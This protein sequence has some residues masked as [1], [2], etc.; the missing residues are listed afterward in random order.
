MLNRLISSAI[1]ILWMGGCSTS[2]EAVPV[3]QGRDEKPAG[4]SLSAQTYLRKL[5]LHLRGQTPTR[6]EYA[7]LAS[8][9]EKH[10]ATQFI[11]G[12]IDEYL[13]SDQHIDKMSGRLE[14]CFCSNP[15]RWHSPVRSSVVLAMIFQFTIL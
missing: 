12:K 6:S 5:S 15:H 11:K 4:P 3:P 9:L 13:A 10:T 8:A 7:D 1:L 2:H 14:D